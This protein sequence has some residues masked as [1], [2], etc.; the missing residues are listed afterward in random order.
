MTQSVDFAS[1]FSGKSDSA[2][3]KMVSDR[4]NVPEVCLFLPLDE[5]IAYRLRVVIVIV[6]GSD[7]ENVFRAS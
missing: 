7:G 2:K 6:S 3:K 1:K 4:S 5:G